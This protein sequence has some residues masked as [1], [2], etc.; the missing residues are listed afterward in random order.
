MLDGVLRQNQV[1]KLRTWPAIPAV[2]LV[3]LAGAAL[4][5]RRRTLGTLLLAAG[6][7]GGAWSFEGEHGVFTFGVVLLIAIGLYL[8]QRGVLRAPD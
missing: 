5:Q 1:H 3:C 8:S 6:A 4:S 7:V 2:W